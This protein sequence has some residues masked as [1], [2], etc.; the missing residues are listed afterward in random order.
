MPNWIDLEEIFPIE[1]IDDNY[2]RKF[3]I[4]N[5]KIVILYSF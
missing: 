3:N 4:S 1:S 5:E 2:Y